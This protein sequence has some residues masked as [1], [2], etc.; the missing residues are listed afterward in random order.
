MIDFIVVPEEEFQGMKCAMVEPYPT[1]A[2]NI[3]R[4]WA[5]MLE[6]EVITQALRPPQNFTQKTLLRWRR[7]NNLFD[8][9]FWGRQ[10]LNT[11]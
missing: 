4:D 1:F 6:K 7:V 11:C 2:H 9:D 5:H 10:K 3:Q 8:K